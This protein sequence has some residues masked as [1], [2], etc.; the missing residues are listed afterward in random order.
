MNR[1]EQDRMKLLLR[2]AVKPMEEDPQPAH[3]LWPQMLARMQERAGAVPWLDWALAG[4]LAAFLA[5]FPVTLP[6]L[7]YC[8]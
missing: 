7:L 1:Q 8:L 3:D 2:E 5:A 4:G 6:V